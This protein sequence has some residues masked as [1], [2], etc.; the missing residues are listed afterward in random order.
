M[1]PLT[2]LELPPRNGRPLR[3]AYL[4]FNDTYG[5]TRVLKTAETAVQAGAEVRIFAIGGKGRRFPAG[6]EVRPNGVEIERFQLLGLGSAKDVWTQGRLWWR[7]VRGRPLAP[8]VSPAALPQV[9]PELETVPPD[10][11]ALED[12]LLA[13]QCPPTDAAVGAAVARRGGPFA[14]RVR[15]IRNRLV[16]PT[17]RLVRRKYR[18]ARRGVYLLSRGKWRAAKRSAFLF[19]N[20]LVKRLN[21]WAVPASYRHGIQAQIIAWAP[22]LIHAHDA[23]TLYPAGRSAKKLGVPFVYDSH[24]L[25]THRNRVS[26][27]ESLRR[28]E[29]RSERYWARRAAR[30]ITVSP[31]IAQWLKKRYRLHEL[32]ELVRN[33]PP[34]DGHL[35]SREGGRLRELAGLQY[36]DKVVVYCGGITTN[37]GI[38]QAIEATAALPRDTHFVLLGYGNE[39]FQAKLLELVE[40]NGVGERVHFIGSVPSAEVSAALADADVSLVLTQPTCLSYAYSLPNKLFESIHAG[41]PV[42]STRLIDAAALID[43]YEVGETVA[44]DAGASELA[45]R[46]EDVIARNSEFHAAAVRAASKLT[47][48]NEAG[49]L[50]AV[51]SQALGVTAR[52][53]NRVAEAV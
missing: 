32:P 29:A 23:N 20:P 19:A 46:M 37:R 50:I 18:R 31:S 34:F 33:I 11:I 36:T 14:R 43:E 1:T 28:K 5:D 15:L 9:E 40:A 25:W 17:S 41:I 48:E 2:T 6:L 51:W 26:V 44:V 49:R 16:V 10:S 8:V 53:R 4:V 35:P 12:E 52:E 7:T 27:S 3:I 13:A 21:R 39:T 22:D 38:E 45:A 24:E 42:L 30:V 47:W